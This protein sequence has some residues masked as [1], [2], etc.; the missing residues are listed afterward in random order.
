LTSFVEE[1]KGK[2]NAKYAFIFSSLQRLS[3]PTPR[4]PSLTSDTRPRTT[5]TTTLCFFQA[6]SRAACTNLAHLEEQG[7]VV[8]LA[9]DAAAR[10]A[11]AVWS[12]RGAGGAGGGAV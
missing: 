1:K 2:N 4:R 10:E 3:L 5:T 9:G 6:A 12:F 11:V 7:L 8:F